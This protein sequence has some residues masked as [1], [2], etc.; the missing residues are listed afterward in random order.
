MTQPRK[1]DYEADIK[2]CELIINDAVNY[3]YYWL[4]GKGKVPVHA[5]E[6]Y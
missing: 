5:M 2:F 4:Y 6:A 3:S 1:K